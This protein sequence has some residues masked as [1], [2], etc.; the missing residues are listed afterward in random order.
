M[1]PTYHSL[2]NLIEMIDEPNRTICLRIL[3]D[4]R[5]LFETV[6]GSSHNHQAWPGGYFDHVKDVMNIGVVLYG[7]LNLIR[8]L[9]FILSD[10]LLVLFLHDIE[11]PWKY[12]IVDGI[13]R[14]KPTLD[15]KPAQREFR[16][17][18]LQEYGILLTSDQENGMMYVEGE[19]KDYSPKQR[20]MNPLAALC[21]LAD[22]TSARIWFDYPAKN[23]P[24]KDATRTEK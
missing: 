7:Q 23:D 1:Q 10:V 22:V 6:Q 11:K 14:I 9:P 4:N 15:E 20:M 2:E 17:R 5:T 3:K 18:K 21:H 8:S 16:N 12:E 13:F 19:Y 24:W